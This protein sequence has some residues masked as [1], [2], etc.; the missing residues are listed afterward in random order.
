M[1]MF[2]SS[3]VGNNGQLPD[4]HALLPAIF[5][6]IAIELG[7]FAYLAWILFV[8]FSLVMWVFVVGFAVLDARFN[9]LEE[10]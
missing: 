9:L 5:E 10:K 1:M 8:L 4:C 3:C 2:L 6:A 7:T